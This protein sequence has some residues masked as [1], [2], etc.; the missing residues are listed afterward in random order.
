MADEED[1]RNSAGEQSPD[2]GGSAAAAG[3]S[4]TGSTDAT[5]TDEG[6]VDDEE[7][8]YAVDEFPTDPAAT[9]PGNGSE[10]GAD[11]EGGN[12]AGS[13]VDLDEEI[14]PGSPSAESVFFVALGV[15]VTV[16]FFLT[17]AGVL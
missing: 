5:G 14:E 10:D 15:L 4:V 7:W 1:D 2:D 12:V 16:L 13:V 8:R 3:T 11:E 6:P 17:A 9:D